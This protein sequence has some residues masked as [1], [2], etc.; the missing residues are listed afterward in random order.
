MTS[1]IRLVISIFLLI[2]GLISIHILNFDPM[3]NYTFAFIFT[4]LA[5]IWFAW[6]IFKTAISKN[7]IY[8]TVAVSLLVRISFIT[9]DPIGS[10]DIYRYMWDGKVQSNGFN[11]YSFAPDAKE[12]KNLHTLLLPGSVNHPGMKTPYLPLS[13]WIFAACYQIS[14]EA[15]W[16][17]KLFL[18]FTETA[19]IIGLF[20]LFAQFKIPDKHVLLYALCP[21]P[22]IQFAI[23]AH[24]DGIGLPLLIFGLLLYKKKNFLPA[25]LLLGLSISIKPVAAVILPVLFLNEKSWKERLEVAVIPVLVVG[26]QFLPYI[27]TANPFDGLITFAKNWTFNGFVFTPAYLYFDNN[28]KARLLC[29]ILLGIALLFLYF[30]KKQFTDK[31]YYSIL[32]LLIFSP[33]VHPWYVT[34]IAVLVPFV[35]RWSG[36]VFAATISLTSLT[37]LNYKLFGNWDQSV[38][39]LVI[40]YLPV[41]VLLIYELFVKPFDTSDGREFYSRPE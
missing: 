14:G 25:L 5:F 10:D 27:F 30:G 37:V 1:I 17:Y 9:I 24:L 36:I 19:A 35:Q 23:D 40:E 6:S 16:G 12:L 41:V 7:F 20:L 38:I 34:W 28:Q 26:L 18:L 2:T 21:L 32:L 22:I 15:V 39:V 33:V 8:L 29:A 31:I 3:I 11:P 13:Q 4:S